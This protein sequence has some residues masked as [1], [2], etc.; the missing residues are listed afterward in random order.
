MAIYAAMVDRLDKQIGR[1]IEDLKAANEFENTLIVFTSDNGACFE[2]DPFGFD[3]V[4]SNQNILHIGDMID[5]MGKPGTSH[6][7]G[8]GWANSSNTPWRL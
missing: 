7:V 4:S 6:S 8:S 1:I 3:I 2:W 5:D